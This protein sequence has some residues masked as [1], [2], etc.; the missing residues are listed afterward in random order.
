MK[1]A[2]AVINARD[3]PVQEPGARLGKKP[4]M[5]EAR[6]EK[7]YIG[8]VGVTP[9][10]CRLAPGASEPTRGAEIIALK[11]KLNKPLRWEDAKWR[12]RKPL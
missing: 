11:E 10:I 9:F 7:Y 12:I 4:R 2:I 6:A 8:A 5:P 3:A 1:R